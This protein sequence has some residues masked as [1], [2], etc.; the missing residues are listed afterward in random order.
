MYVCCCYTVIAL[1]T[2]YNLRQQTANLN[3]Y[4]EAPHRVVVVLAMVHYKA[5]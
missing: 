1:C 3:I 4:A 2:L 5:N